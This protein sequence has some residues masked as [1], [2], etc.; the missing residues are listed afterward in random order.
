MAVAPFQSGYNTWPMVWPGVSGPILGN[1]PMETET[2]DLYYVGTGPDQ[3][4][5]CWGL[6][7]GTYNK[8]T[9]GIDEESS[10]LD[11]FRAYK[12]PSGHVESV[13]GF[14]FNREIDVIP[15]SDLVT[16]EV[17]G[18]E[19]FRH[20]LS[21]VERIIA[22]VYVE[23]NDG[24]RRFNF[25]GRDPWAY[26]IGAFEDF[27]FEWALV[28]EELSSKP[29]CMASAGLVDRVQGAI[30]PGVPVFPPWCDARYGSRVQLG[31]ASQW[32]IPARSRVRLVCTIRGASG[33][34]VRLGGRVSGYHQQGGKRKAAI[35]SA[36]SRRT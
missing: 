30:L 4:F 5:R 17:T 29:Q 15:Q 36:V 22:N 19:N 24:E 18:F 32:L 27:G 31:P 7:A 13:R 34:F 20:G 25:D 28:R 11:D 23:M 12:N 26:E 35:E 16:V 1:P 33:M 21:I 8:K 6:A 9:Y 10:E 3:I 2:P 14:D